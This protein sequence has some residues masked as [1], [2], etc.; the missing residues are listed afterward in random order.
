MDTFPFFSNR[1]RAIARLVEQGKALINDAAK[2]E[3][4]FQINEVFNPQINSRLSR[5]E[6]NDE[7]L[8]QSILFE[9]HGL[10]ITLLPSDT[11]LITNYKSVLDEL[12]D[13]CRWKHTLRKIPFGEAAQ[14]SQQRQTDVLQGIIHLANGPEPTRIRRLTRMLTKSDQQAIAYRTL[15]A[16][17]SCLY[18]EK[19]P[20][21]TTALFWLRNG[22][23][24]LRIKPIRAYLFEQIALRVYISHTPTE[25][26]FIEEALIS[27]HHWVRSEVIKRVQTINAELEEGM[28][29]I[30]SQVKLDFLRKCQRWKAEPEM[31]YLDAKLATYLFAF[32]RKSHAIDKLLGIENEEIKPKEK[33]E[34]N[35]DSFDDQNG[36]YTNW[37]SS[38]DRDYLDE[39]KS[40]LH[41]CL[42]KLGEKC[43]A[44][45]L[46][47]YDSDFSEPVPFQTLAFEWRESP[48]TVE[49]RFYD[50]MEK[51]KKMAH[52]TL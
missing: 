15:R 7:I 34:D 50:C 49:S 33:P 26:F 1:R 45:I 8:Q 20:I 10:T 22:R 41:R 5:A 27:V 14:S 46:R 21:Q 38:G 30:V 48:K 23:V 32:V 9:L 19:Q 25:A 40:I 47:H 28:K 52:G 51:L 37:H 2:E 3:F 12:I 36:S 42:K 17:L 43:R 35:N 11:H 16:F 13:A 31:F 39:Q 6:Q 24:Q 29:D 44:I 18:Q 4:T